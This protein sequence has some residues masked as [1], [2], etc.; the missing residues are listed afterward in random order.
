MAEIDSGNMKRADTRALKEI[1]KNSRNE[2]NNKIVTCDKCGA[3][4]LTERKWTIHK[5]YCG[6]SK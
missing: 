3:I 5:K 2:E 1:L 4:L 6:A